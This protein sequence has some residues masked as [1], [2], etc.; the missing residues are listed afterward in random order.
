MCFETKLKRSLCCGILRTFNML[1]CFAKFLE[2]LSDSLSNLA[3]LTPSDCWYM[4][5]FPITIS[6]FILFL[7][8]QVHMSKSHPS[9]KTHHKHPHSRKLFLFFPSQSGLFPPLSF[10]SHSNSASILLP[11]TF[12]NADLSQCSPIFKTT[13]PRP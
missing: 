8:P 4:V 11:V 13:T 10:Y 5:N 9:F 12:A 3:V 2:N 6:L 7:Q 1:I